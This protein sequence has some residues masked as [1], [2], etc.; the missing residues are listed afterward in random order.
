[1]TWAELP[2]KLKIFISFL[3][4]AAFPLMVWA[5]RDVLIGGYN[6]GWIVLAVLTLLTVI[7][8]QYLP[9]A[10][11]TVSIGDAYIM[12]IAMIFGTAPCIIATF[13]HTI[14]ICFTKKPRIPV[15]RI[16]FNTSSE[17]CGAWIYSSI[18]HSM[19][20]DN[21]QIVDI[22]LPAVL[23]IT[24]YFL[25]NSLLT[26]IA[27]SWSIGENVARFWAKNCMPL[28][29]DFSVSAVAATII[30]T[31]WKENP[32]IM[33]AAIPVMGVIWGWYKVNKARAEELEKHLNEQEQ[34]Y[35]RTV[36]SLALA[37]DAK[38]QT[39]YGHIRRVRVYATRMAH[40]CGITDPDELKAIETGSLLHDIGKLAIDDYILNKPGK[41][42]RQEFEKIKMHAAA[43]DEILKQIRF[44][45]PV[46]KY[47]RYHHERYDGK[48]YPDGLKG[49]GIPLGARILA[50]SD[51]FDAIRFSRPYKLPISTREA[52]EILQDQSGTA[53]DPDLI[54]IF[55]NHVGELEREAEIA[56]VNIDEL[57]FRKYFE[58]VDR[59]L[60]SAD[61]TSRS[62]S[63][64]QDI[65]TEILQVAEFCSTAIGYF[66]LQDFL[67]ILA[68]RIERLIPFSTCAFFLVD[69][70]GGV[71]AV[72]TCG[73]FSDKLRGHRIVMGKGI[74]GY[75]TA[76][77]RP[78]VN[79]DPLL[80]FHGLEG[81]FS[82]FTDT[83]AVPIIFNDEAL[84][85]I[86]LYAQKPVS[87][88]QE[89]LGVLQTL[90]NSLAPMVS[91]AIN[92]GN[93]KPED[94]VDPTTQIHRIS[95]LTAIGPQ[96]ISVA[97]RNQSPICLIYLE[98]RN[99]YQ[100][101]RIY[102]GNIG[103]AVLKRIALCIKTELRETDVLVRYGHQ[104]F[105]A[106]LPGVRIEHARRCVLRL[107]Q[108]IR[109]EVSCVGGQNF[110]ID[111]S[112]GISAYPK[113]GSA[114]F[115]LLQSAKESQKINISDSVL[116][117]GNVI[118][119]LPRA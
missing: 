40:L 58:N 113:D 77:R 33:L 79:T 93:E 102:G 41:L 76:H 25:I 66:D 83:L 46:S 42:T 114:I 108:Q 118:D 30:A 17:I 82:S 52:V 88:K 47:V 9:S 34:L 48:G 110:S 37:V 64:S 65:P 119:F 87:Y 6:S 39:T 24:A 63:P 91:E 56:S 68:R 107:K 99:L 22:F 7:G 75:V 100:I 27:I 54:K 11:A 71:S 98:I 19:Y 20:R 70:K 44:P 2:A 50:I 26:S 92:R 117:D 96:L 5:V 78:M 43:G 14:L 85:T 106:L 55:T 59:E 8:F 36:E 81:D 31:V 32:Y 23:L 73:T 45:F 74:S 90:A 105:V 111:C 104:G 112:A 103:N 109:N 38:D 21:S 12:A 13:C 10:N 116:T 1:M 35:L 29:I 28:A 61:V 16:A 4:I 80:D 89:D 101:M 60:Q 62:P 69:D 53:Y 95:Y 15:Y 51:A 94:S 57:S 72:Y 3:T 67:P 84:G 49:E 115:A 86:S 97:A 18:F